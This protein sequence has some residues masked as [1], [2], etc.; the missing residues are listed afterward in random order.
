MLNSAIIMGRMAQDPELKTTQSGIS[1]CRFAVACERSYSRQGEEKK[2]DFIDVTAWRQTADFIAKN[3]PKGAMIAI[4][5][6]IQVES[7]VDKQGIKRKDV[8]VVANN[9]SFCGSKAETGTS[10]STVKASAE[11]N[12][13]AVQNTQPEPSY[14]SAEAADFDEIV[15]DED[16]L[17]F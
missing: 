13:P 7:Y 4:E 10:T 16:D 17:P 6:S 3:F 11:Q 8:R 5:G 14:S 15:S 9:A 12:T 2:V 1:V